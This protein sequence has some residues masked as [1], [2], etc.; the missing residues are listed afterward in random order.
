MSSLFGAAFLRTV[1]VVGSREKKYETENLTGCLHSPER[2]RSLNSR[3]ERGQ[4][5]S[6]ENFWLWAH[7][8]WG[9][10]IGLKTDQSKQPWKGLDFLQI[11]FIFELKE[12]GPRWPG[13]P[14]S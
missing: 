5:G 8:P 11:L 10:I 1:C 12:S 13:A 2:N 7:T 6:G 3:L 14:S 4:K 9:Y